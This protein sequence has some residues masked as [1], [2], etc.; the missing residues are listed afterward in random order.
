M[1][2]NNTVLGLYR[3]SGFRAAAQGTPADNSQAHERFSDARTDAPR[4]FK[5]V[6]FFGSSISQ[7]DYFSNLSQRLDKLS[8]F[9]DG[10]KRNAGSLNDPSAIIV[11]R[12]HNVAS[13]F[14]YS[15]TRDADGTVTEEFSFQ[16]RY[17]PSGES[18]FSQFSSA[19]FAQYSD[20]L[21]A[22]K[23]NR[24]TE[25]SVA[26]PA[27]EAPIETAAPIGDDI[28]AE[29]KEF[30]AGVTE[31]VSD[32]AEGVLA[33][34]KLGSLYERLA[35]ESR[36]FIARIEKLIEYYK[37]DSSAPSETPDANAPATT[38]GETIAETIAQPATNPAPAAPLSD[39]GD[40][41]AETAAIETL[42]NIIKINDEFAS[43]IAASDGDDI[44]DIAAD[45]ARRIQ[46]GD[47]DDAVTI[48]A[49]GVTRVDS[50]DGD[51]TVSIDAVRA[52]RISTGDGDDA[53]SINADIARRIDTGD[54]DDE[55]TIAAET[56][57][58]INAG[59][60][61][62]TLSLAAETIRR[63]DAGAG[64]DTI[65]LDARDAVIGFN[66]GGGE[67]VINVGNVGALGIDIDSALAS[68]IDDI[69][70]TAEDDQ[71]VLR[72]A[73]GESLT[74]ND[75]GNADLISVIVGGEKII[76]QVG[77]A[78]LSLNATA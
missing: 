46:S 55:L 68:S 65:T 13:S 70:F 77:D 67:D 64:D 1:E 44:I 35:G 56:I 41:A 11:E 31:K 73:S 2:L 37:L 17:R 30:A 58:R 52:S 60:G 12:P 51:D 24:S 61:D 19:P 78:P 20:F 59:D 48:S 39:A 43:R 23:H 75:R 42:A 18:Q 72:F 16:I 3:E 63:V 74:I 27:I 62:D 54:G 53:V 7:S 36:D 69:D 47:G 8:S 38:D 49:K 33:Q 45:Y 21:H 28:V 50:G 34:E 29:A 25:P 22:L 10:V 15:S 66:A 14:S 71:L 6:S 40:G 5:S 32:A 9:F 26:A 76:L 4:S 57:R